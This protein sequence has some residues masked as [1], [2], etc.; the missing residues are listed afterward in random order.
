M[1]SCCQ[2]SYVQQPSLFMSSCQWHFLN[3]RDI[4]SIGVILSLKGKSVDINQDES[5]FHQG[6]LKKKGILK[7]QETESVISIC[8]K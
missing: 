7:Q 1:K 5:S 6:H 3:T 2:V 8:V 4:I